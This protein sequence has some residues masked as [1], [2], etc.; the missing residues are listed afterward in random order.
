MP[1]CLPDWTCRPEL[2]R[3]LELSRRPKKI[4][5][6]GTWDPGIFASCTA[7]VGSRR[8]TSYGR[9]VTEMAVRKLVESG[10]TIISGFM[11]G[12]DQYAHQTAIDSGGKTIAVL[13]W[14]INFPLEDHDRKLAEA[15]VE[16][17]GLLLSEWDD[18]KPALW[19]FP[20]RNRIVAALSSDVIVIEAAVKSGSLITANLARK[21]RRNVWA[22]PGPVTSRLSEGTNLLLSSGQAKFWLR[23]QGQNAKVTAS[24]N[25]LVTAVADEPLTANDLA[26]KLGLPVADVGAQLSLLTV[27]G[28]IVERDGKFMASYVN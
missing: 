5:Y 19:T 24:G 28:E 11:Y 8:M 13:G 26:R 27:T 17:G 14:G 7:V 2:S 22:V 25:P 10:Q 1:V 9:Q 18:Q 15:I 21:L 12:V 6:E 20:Y 3:L 16:N 4:Y 23:D